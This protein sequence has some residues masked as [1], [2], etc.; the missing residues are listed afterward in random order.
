MSKVVLEE[1]LADPFSQLKNKAID[2]VVYD[3][4]QLMYYLKNNKDKKLN[5]SKAAY[6]NQGYGFAFPM[7]TEITHHVKV[8]LLELAERKEIDRILSYWLGEKE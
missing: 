1:N 7:N 3:R 5:I 2:A 6:Y 8:E 4:P